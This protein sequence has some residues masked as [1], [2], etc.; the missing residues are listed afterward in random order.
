MKK[1]SLIVF[2]TL[3]ALAGV[4]SC[5]REEI[6]G[7]SREI[8]LSPVTQKATK[9]ILEGTVFP[10][11]SSFVVSA[12]HTNGVYFSDLVASYDNVSG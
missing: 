12:I 8:Y 10:T 1:R 7:G 4:C 6:T 9:G 5:T 2:L 3:A 11:D